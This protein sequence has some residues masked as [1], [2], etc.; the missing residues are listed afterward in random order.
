MSNMNVGNSVTPSF[1]GTKNMMPDSGFWVPKTVSKDLNMDPP[2][3]SPQDIF[4]K[5]FSSG[6][7]MN[8]DDVLMKKQTSTFDGLNNLKLPLGVTITATQP[9]VTSFTTAS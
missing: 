5:S 1:S 4:S 8:L 6:S 2:T 7:G 9:K 3:F